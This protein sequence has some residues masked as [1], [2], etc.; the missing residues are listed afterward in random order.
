[1]TLV[2]KVA[3][4]P[5]TTNQPKNECALNLSLPIEKNRR[6]SLAKNILPLQDEEA[7]QL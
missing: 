7:V 2:V 1:M 3:L 5:N 4:N 6:F